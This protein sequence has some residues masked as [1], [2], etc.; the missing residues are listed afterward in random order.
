MFSCYS[1][2]SIEG[3]LSANIMAKRLSKALRGKRR[4]FGIAFSEKY[5]ARNIVNLALNQIGKEQKFNKM[6]RLM[7]FHSATGEVSGSIAELID[8]DLDLPEFESLGFGIVEVPLEYSTTFREILSSDETINS[9]GMKSLTMSG[10]I[11]L[12]RERLNLPKPKR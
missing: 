10:K 4:W 11:R 6:L 12:V 1:K 2:K 7:D 5:S 3:V 8:L 9:Y